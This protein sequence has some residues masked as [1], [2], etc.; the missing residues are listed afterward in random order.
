M[1]ESNMEALAFGADINSVALAILLPR[2][3]GKASEAMPLEKPTAKER[4]LRI[5]AKMSEDLL[6]RLWISRN[7]EK[8][9]L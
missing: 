6:K 5:G 1:D 3:P 7:K 2:N 9:L 8:D 4:I